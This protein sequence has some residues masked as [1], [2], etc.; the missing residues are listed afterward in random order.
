MKTL[1]AILLGVL[2]WILIFVEISIFRIGLKITGWTQYLIHYVFL[3]V[4]VVLCAAIYY[5][6]KDKFNGF[7]LGLLLLL[8]GNILDL[9]IT[10]PIFLKG[11]FSGFYINVWL[12][13]GFLLVI[14]TS[15]IYD[16]G[17]KR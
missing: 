4:F 7:G 14:V 3:I 6:S 5:K 13:V 11:D 15:G 17:R 12:W 16:L 8:V 9:A 2:L 10:V 1:R